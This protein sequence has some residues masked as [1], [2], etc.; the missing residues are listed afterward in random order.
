MNQVHDQYKA[1]QRN[2]EDLI[3]LLLQEPHENSQHEQVL[4][5]AR[6][7]LHKAFAIER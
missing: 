3:G 6:A 1:L 2:I 4:A 5:Q 7:S